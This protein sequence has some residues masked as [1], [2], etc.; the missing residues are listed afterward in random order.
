MRFGPTSLQ[1]SSVLAKGLRHPKLRS[2]LR[3]S[4]QTVAGETSYVV[5]I[6]ETSSY[7]RYGATEFEL[8]KMC[9]GTRTHAEIAQAMTERHPDEPLTEAEVLEFIDSIEPAMWEQSLGEKNLAVLERIR[10]ERKSRIDQSSVFYISFKAWDPDKVLTKLDPYLGWMFTRGFVLFSIGI[11]VVTLYALSGDWTRIQHDTAAFYSFANKTSY[12]IWAFWLLLFLLSA[13]HELGHGLTCKHFGGEVHQMGLLLIYFTPAFFTDTTDIVLFPRTAHRQWVIFAGLWV[14]IVVCCF[15]GLTW[16]F[17]AAGSLLNDLA[18]KMM[19]LSGVQSVLLNLNPLIKAD[20]YYALSQFLNVDNLREESF[21]YLRA[22][23]RKYLLRHDMDLPAA[24]RRHA[25]IFLTFGSLAILYS[26]TLVLIFL[27]FFKNV[28]VSKFGN[29]G[30]LL[31]AL[32]VY[33]FSRKGLQKALPAVRAW[34]REKKENYMAWK[35]SRRQQAGALVVALL[36]L[37]PPVPSNVS[38][39]MILEPGKDARVRAEVTGKIRK[40]LVRQGDLVEAGQVLAV[41]ENPGIEATAQV[42]AQ[43]LALASSNVRRDLD[44]SD[45]DKAAQAAQERTRLQRQLAV[46]QNN[47]ALEDI[48]APFSGVVTTVEVEERVGESL[49]AGGEFCQVVDRSRMKAR[50]LVRDWELEDVHPGAPAKVKVVPFPYR[51][52]AGRVEQ[53]LPAAALDRPVAQPQKLEH[54]GQ[55]LTN[56]FAVTMEFPNPDGSLR[57]GMT[58]TAKISGRNYPLAWQAGRAAWRW[59][60]SQVW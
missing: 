5:K 8:L 17:S 45:F 19:L 21:S 39:D 13:I 29:W 30:Y 42:L 20:G 44:R 52:Y 54:L 34:L 26:V 23:V 12:D 36:L 1:V 40:V 51:T 33:Y 7:N 14:E 28:L 10:D 38:T 37:V 57:E 47:V 60:R 18:Y 49:A 2:D 9:D 22:W 24:S 41:L 46:A 6:S 25:R 50:I 27:V 43:Q 32:V 55:E 3:I 4:E 11:F 58:G 35:M 16:H 59:V 31:T 53:I 56:Y 15:S 48:R